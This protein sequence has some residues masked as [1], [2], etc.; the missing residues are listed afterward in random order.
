MKEWRNYIQINVVNREALQLKLVTTQSETGLNHL[1]KLNYAR[2]MLYHTF[3]LMSSTGSIFFHFI[4][5]FIST[6]TSKFIV[7]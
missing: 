6:H 1:Q 4:L 3:H 7:N 5:D 2:R